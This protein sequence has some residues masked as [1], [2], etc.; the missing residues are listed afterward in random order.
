[1]SADVPP[2]PSSS[3]APDPSPSSIAPLAALAVARAGS[4]SSL[5]DMLK[6]ML[7]DVPPEHREKVA[8]MVR[9][10][11]I[12]STHIGPLPPPEQLAAYNAIIPNGADRI[13]KMAENQST[14]RI[15]LENTVIK[16]QQIQAGRGQLFG[17]I[18]GLSGLGLATFAAVK[19][20]PWFGAVIGGSTLVS[21]AGV[22]VYS[23]TQERR[24]LKG[25]AEE[26]ESVNPKSTQQSDGPSIPRA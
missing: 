19:G 24:E 18:I 9:T 12:R 14:H 23:Q 15:D 11:I 3:P 6:E 20:Q 8:V 1:M 26:M 25:K 4:F 13:M 7:K 5:E 21:L 16:S 10:Q 17:A 22:F 2:S